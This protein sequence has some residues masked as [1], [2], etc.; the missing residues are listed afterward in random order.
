[1]Y[2]TQSHLRKQTH[3]DIIYNNIIPIRCNELMTCK[4]LYTNIVI[5][6]YARRISNLVNS[7]NT[8]IQ[9]VPISIRTI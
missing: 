2:Y 1:M 7:E 8:L 3:V 9:T 4:L 5:R 6:L